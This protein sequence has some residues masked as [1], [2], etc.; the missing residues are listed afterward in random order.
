MPALENTD[1]PLAAHSPPL[2]I[3]E[4][5]LLLLLPGGFAAGLLVR[6]R[7]S[8]HA[9]LGRFGDVV[10]AVETGVGGGELGHAVENLFVL[11]NGGDQQI[12]VRGPPVVHLVGRYYLVLRFLNLGHLA[13]LGRLAGLPTP[14]N[15]CTRLEDARQFS[16]VMSVT[17]YYP[18]L[19]LRNHFLG[20]FN[21]SRQLR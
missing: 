12:A 1:A 19:G 7:H 16:F 5:S 13:E 6:N 2:S 17:V 3:L 15:L 21:Y 18:G 10:G 14:Y 20:H 11:L 4:P 8:V 9:S